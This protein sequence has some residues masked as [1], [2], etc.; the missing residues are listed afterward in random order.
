[1]EDVPTPTSRFPTTWPEVRLMS[2][3]TP[4]TTLLVPVVMLPPVSHSVLFTVMSAPSAS[5]VGLLRPTQSNVS[6]PGAESSC[7][8]DEPLKKTARLLGANA[9][10]MW[11]QLPP[12][13]RSPDVPLRAKVP[14]VRVRLPGQ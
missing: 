8:P 11:T 6:P 12:T 9:P 13:Y 4:I 10:P 2:P 1:V 7:G 3:A 5:P 14:L